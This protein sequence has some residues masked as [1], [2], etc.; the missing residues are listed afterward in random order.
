MANIGDVHHVVD[1]VTGEF[2]KT[3][4]QV[5]EQEAAKVADVSKV[6]NCRTAAVYFDLARRD[7]REVFELIGQRVIESNLHCRRLAAKW[8]ARKP[9]LYRFYEVRG[10][11]GAT[12]QS[13]SNP[14][15]RTTK[16]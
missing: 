2:Q 7:G 13:L 11:V 12:W 6:V 5:P 15:S 9:I 1:F 4:Q 16:D 14:R 8:R 10:K 3:A